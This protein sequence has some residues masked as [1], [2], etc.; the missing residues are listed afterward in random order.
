MEAPIQP[1]WC[2]SSLIRVQ[3]APA[4]VER[5]TP[6]TPPIFAV[7]KS[8]WYEAPAAALPKPTE[9]ACSTPD[10]LVNVAPESVECH[11]P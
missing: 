7:T 3:V 9:S 4:S 1:H 5:K 6:R 8:V 11:S 10:S 2:A